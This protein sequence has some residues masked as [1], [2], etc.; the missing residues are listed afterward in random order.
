M[1]KGTLSWFLKGR[2]T[3][4]SWVAS[5]M[6]PEL[7]VMRNILSHVLCPEFHFKVYHRGRTCLWERLEVK[8]SHLAGFLCGNKLCRRLTQTTEQ[9]AEMAPSWRKVV[10]YNHYKPPKGRWVCVVILTFGFLVMGVLVVL[11]LL[12][13]MFL[14]HRWRGSKSS[15]NTKQ[16]LQAFLDHQPPSHDTETYYFIFMNAQP[17]LRLISS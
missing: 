8:R 7:Y 17:S 14:R 4:W 15:K 2:E 6:F 5:H 10:W 13:N 12:G 16:C 3:A 11:C 1:C 9:P